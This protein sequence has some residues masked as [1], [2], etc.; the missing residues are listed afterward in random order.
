[1]KGKRSVRR[2]TRTRTKAS[3]KYIR[4]RTSR[5]SVRQRAAAR[6]T[7][8]I[9]RYPS[10]RYRA[11]VTINGNPDLE[12]SSDFTLRVMSNQLCDEA[13]CRRKWSF[14][15]PEFLKEKVMGTHRSVYTLE[16]VSGRKTKVNYRKASN[17]IEWSYTFDVSDNGAKED[18]IYFSL[19]PEKE[20]LSAITKKI[21]GD[22]PVYRVDSIEKINDFP[23]EQHPNGYTYRTGGTFDVA[24]TAFRREIININPQALQE[25]DD[26][27]ASSDT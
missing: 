20:V 16:H 27:E 2:S 7:R 6:L 18:V 9:Y 24:M 1:M 26:A 4:S 25:G 22:N 10:D 14:V 13:Q 3:R 5:V 21:Y 19:T 8:G 11:G 17:R 15:V 23:L 12:F